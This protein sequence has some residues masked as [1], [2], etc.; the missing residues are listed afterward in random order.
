MYPQHHSLRLHMRYERIN[1]SIKSTSAKNHDQQKASSIRDGDGL[2]RNENPVS[3]LAKM[4]FPPLPNLYL[5]P[6]LEAR[7]VKAQYSPAVP[8]LKD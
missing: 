6:V 5:L 4:N 1:Q 3:L 7:P 2:R 8:F